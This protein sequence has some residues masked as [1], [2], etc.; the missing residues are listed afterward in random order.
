[1]E[2]VQQDFILNNLKKYEKCDINIDINFNTADIFD[3]NN[4]VIEDSLLKYFNIVQNM[5][6]VRCIIT[7]LICHNSKND[8]RILCKINEK[9]KSKWIQM[10]LSNEGGR[11]GVISV[12]VQR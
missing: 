10:Y 2:I 5:E 6:L 1:M 4:Y 11:H 7:N 9:Y 3:F 8:D 12:S